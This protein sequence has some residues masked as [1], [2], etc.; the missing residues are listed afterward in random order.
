MDK[1]FL[2]MERAYTNSGEVGDNKISSEDFSEFLLFVAKQFMDF[3]GKMD[4]FRKPY[5]NHYRQIKKNYPDPFIFITG[6]GKG[7]NQ[8]CSLCN[9]YMA[10]PCNFPGCIELVCG[11]QFHSWCYANEVKSVGDTRCPICGVFQPREREFEECRPSNLQ[12]TEYRF[13]DRWNHRRLME[14]IRRGK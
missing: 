10:Y 8:K 3:F 9:K 1:D 5:I 11:H 2:K 7:V 14:N 12:Y 6:M 4:F 13:D